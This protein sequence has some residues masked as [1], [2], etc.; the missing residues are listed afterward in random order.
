MNMNDL[1]KC[2]LNTLVVNGVKMDKLPDKYEHYEIKKIV[3]EKSIK[4]SESCFDISGYY[5]TH[6]R[7]ELV[8][9]LF[10]RVLIEDS[11][12]AYV[13][14]RCEFRF[15]GMTIQQISEIMRKLTEIEDNI[16]FSFIKCHVFMDDENVKYPFREAP[17]Y[18]KDNKPSLIDFNVRL[19]LLIPTYDSDIDTNEDPS[20]YTTYM[21]Q[22]REERN[23]IEEEKRIR[24]ML[25]KRRREDLLKRMG[26]TKSATGGVG[27]PRDNI[28]TSVRK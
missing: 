2:K 8:D 10:L 23:Q 15:H 11:I 26:K 18:H 19:N 28:N 14:D 22:R 27:V 17:M 3:D 13:F 20:V 16:Q 12:I 25:D 6:D 7:N 21:L 9:L 1:R 5:K 4:F 24:E